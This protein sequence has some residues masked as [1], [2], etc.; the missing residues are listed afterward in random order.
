[1]KSRD[2]IHSNF[3]K[4]K[5]SYNLQQIAKKP[6]TASSPPKCRMASQVPSPLAVEPPAGFE[7]QNRSNLFHEGQLFTSTDDFEASESK[8]GG[9]ELKQFFTVQNSPMNTSI[10]DQF[11]AQS[12]NPAETS[13]LLNRNH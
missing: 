4:S 5:E 12:Q 8:P 7:F 6:F 1:M 3:R 9:R 13:L 2:I 11:E 10:D